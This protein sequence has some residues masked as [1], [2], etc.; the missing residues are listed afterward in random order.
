MTGP[1]IVTARA[2]ADLVEARRV[3]EAALHTGRAVN[4][5]AEHR[6][7]S[8][9]VV[10]VVPVRDGFLALTPAASTT[11]EHASA[12]TAL[13]RPFAMASDLFATGIPERERRGR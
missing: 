11:G 2:P 9:L 4:V 1:A 13:R 10:R 7:A 6:G 5:F 12:E 3:A 8:S